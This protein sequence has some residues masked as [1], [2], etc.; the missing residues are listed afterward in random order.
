MP[1]YTSLIVVLFLF[2]SGRSEGPTN[3][4]VDLSDF[5]S[6]PETTR[7][8]PALID[9]LPPSKRKSILK[10]DAMNKNESE[11][12]LDA[13]R[14]NVYYK[15]CQDDATLADS[16]RNP[17][18][19]PPFTD[20]KNF[21]I[22]AEP[23]I[24]AN[25]N[26]NNNVL[27]KDTNT[28]KTEHIMHQSNSAQHVP[29]KQPS[30]ESNTDDSQLNTFDKSE[31]EAMFSDSLAVSSF[32]I[33]KGNIWQ[34]ADIHG[35]T[36]W[37]TDTSPSDNLEN[38][39]NFF[40]SFGHTPSEDIDPLNQFHSASPPPQLFETGDSTNKIKGESTNNRYTDMK[41]NSSNSDHSEKQEKPNKIIPLE[42]LMHR[43]QRTPS[44]E[45]SPTIP[46]PGAS[47]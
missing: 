12:L 18:N 17:F 14:R 26:R 37:Q 25:V 6:T 8:S 39:D 29:V 20:V 46:S 22:T 13:N 5:T 24:S 3:Y 38:D 11:N 47:G 34:N 2:S 43:L 44:C 4:L 23:T 16:D 28:G 30:S 32:N 31:E 40:G 1:F 33:G 42:Q 41:N 35:F 45:T 15:T 7:S 21:N 27:V 36:T 9:M 10:K 19:K